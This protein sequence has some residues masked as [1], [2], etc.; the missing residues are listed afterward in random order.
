VAGGVGDGA[1]YQARVGRE[2]VTQHICT[3][4]IAVANCMGAHAGI[5][6][7]RRS[8]SLEAPYLVAHD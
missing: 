8:R 3:L 2:L 7:T 5:A 1:G 6:V 4:K